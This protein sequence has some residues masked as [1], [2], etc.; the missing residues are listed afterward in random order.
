MSSRHRVGHRKNDCRMILH[1][2]VQAMFLLTGT[3]ALLAS[4]LNWEWFFTTDNT[5][6]LV[7]RLGLTGARWAY[8]AIGT[9][10]IAAAIYFY[11]K[12]EGLE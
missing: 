12:I 7:K 1:T 10:F 5:R 6:F 8:G 9:V 11:F 4:L 2:V 3:I